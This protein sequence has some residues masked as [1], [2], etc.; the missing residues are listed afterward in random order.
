MNKIIVIVFV[1]L[2]TTNCSFNSKSKFWT[3]EKKIQV[4]QDSK[5]TEIFK[6]E[7]IFEK[8]LNP[9]LKIK[10]SAKPIKNSFINNFDNN[11]GRTNNN[12]SLMIIM[13]YM[14]VGSLH[15]FIQSNHKTLTKADRHLFI[16]GAAKGIY[17]MHLKQKCHHDI[18]P[19]N[20]L[21]DDRYNVKICD[22][23]T[24]LIPKP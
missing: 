18:K 2:L 14:K 3:K 20:M 6:K 19:G 15:K 21:L 17:G 7:K 8:E 24:H 12:G 5:I 9:E 10:L 13:E 22:L 4:D 1:F 23:E 11:N 16:A